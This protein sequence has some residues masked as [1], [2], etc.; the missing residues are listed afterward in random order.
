MLS[1]TS[2]EQLRGPNVT[3]VVY[4][5]AFSESRSTRSFNEES[6]RQRQLQRQSTRVNESQRDEST[7]AV[8]INDSQRQRQSTRV[9]EES[10]RQSTSTRTVNDNQRQSASTSVNVNVSQSVN[11]NVNVSQSVSQ[12]VNVNVCQRGSM[13]TTKSTR[14]VNVKSQRGQSTSRGYKKDRRTA[15]FAQFS[16]SS[17]RRHISCRDSAQPPHPTSTSSSSSW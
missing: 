16:T 10:Q 13:S 3:A 6:Q 8:Y 7:W 14:K 5:V 15:F 9:N 12:S 1:P 2:G 11:V 17:R 4:E